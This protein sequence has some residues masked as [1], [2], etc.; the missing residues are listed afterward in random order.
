MIHMDTRCQ[1]VLE[2]RHQF[3]LYAQG[4]RL[5]IYSVRLEAN[6]DR[7]VIE[8]GGRRFYFH[9]RHEQRQLRN[10]QL[11][12]GLLTIA[13]NSFEIHFTSDNSIVHEGFELF[14]EP[15]YGIYRGLKYKR[16]H[17]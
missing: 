16:S 12:V 15:F 2:A 5:T 4:F 6:H 11:G 8:G 1:T 14:Y 7:L 10:G 13:A 3:V 9:G 17:F